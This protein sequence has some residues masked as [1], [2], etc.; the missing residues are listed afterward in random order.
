MEEQNLNELLSKKEPSFNDFYSAI[1]QKLNELDKIKL[2]VLLLEINQNLS[3]TKEKIFLQKQESFNDL[4][5]AILQ[6]LTV[7]EKRLI[8]NSLKVMAKQEKSVQNNLSETAIEKTL[9]WKVKFRIDAF[10]LNCKT[11]LL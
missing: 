11:Y 4:Y 7:P 10:C 9:K 8:L 1:S 5:N 2:M 6:K 3:D